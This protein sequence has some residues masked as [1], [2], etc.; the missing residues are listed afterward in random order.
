MKGRWW[1]K[2]TEMR[3]PSCSLLVS[4]PGPQTEIATKLEF[5]N[6]VFEWK[7]LQFSCSFLKKIYYHHLSTI[8]KM[9]TRTTAC[10]KWVKYN[11]ISRASF[12]PIRHM[13]IICWQ[14]K[15]NTGPSGTPDHLIP[16]WW[17]ATCTKFLRW[18]HERWCYWTN[19]Q[20]QEEESGDR[21]Y[22]EAELQIIAQLLSKSTFLFRS[23]QKS[24]N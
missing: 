20:M 24:E 2:L 22:T 13:L 14:T 8:N 15:N 10:E 1:D 23:L 4:P 5:S 9:T 17:T 12:I 3:T 16:I 7:C 11:F 19:V 18:C 21:D 6:S